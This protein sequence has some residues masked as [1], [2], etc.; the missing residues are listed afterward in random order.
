MKVKVTDAEVVDGTI[1]EDT[2][3][4]AKKLTARDC[5]LLTHLTFPEDSPL[6][7]IDLTGCKNLKT[8]TNLPKGLTDLILDRCGLEILPPLPEGLDL[9]SLE[10]S[11][12]KRIDPKRLPDSLT[13]L[14]LRG[15]ENIVYTAELG[16]KIDEI[17]R[18]ENSLVILPD[19]T[20]A[21]PEKEAESKTV[22]AGAGAGAGTVE[23]DK[24]NIKVKIGN[25]Q[26]IDGRIDPALLAGATK[27]I[28][29][30]CHDL[31]YLDNLPDSVKELRILGCDGIEKITKLPTALKT[32]HIEDCAI[33]KVI[34]PDSMPKEMKTI[35]VSGCPR[36]E[37]MDRPNSLNTLE[38]PGSNINILTKMQ[39]PGK[40]K[41]LNLRDSKHLSEI[42]PECLDNLEYLDLKG[43]T[44]LIITQ[45]LVDK[46][47]ELKSIPGNFIFAPEHFGDLTVGVGSAESKESKGVG[48]AAAAAPSVRR[49]NRDIPPPLTGPRTLPRVVGNIP[50]PI[51]TGHTR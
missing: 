28:L 44:S 26:I 12:I 18:R 19:G 25:D 46:L 3:S 30:D 20:T 2:L 15:C 10:R 36:L 29:T 7:V 23:E 41:T 11:A 34:E 45:E 6:Q 40:L 35:R 14:E 24:P 50:P 9:L 21:D 49:L 51:N 17:A 1:S 13:Q 33:F 38:M 39:V 47:A 31:K 4:T 42:E 37:E 48:A 8:I 43:C 16:E 27:V 5:T 32:L 22:T